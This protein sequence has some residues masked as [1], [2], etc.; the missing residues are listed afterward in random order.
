MSEM[1]SPVF[2]KTPSK[3]QKF[4]A[5]AK[6]W[7][8][9]IKTR[10]G[11]VLTRNLTITRKQFG[12]IVVLI[13]LFAAGTIPVVTSVWV[14]TPIID[15]DHVDLAVILSSSL[16]VVGAIF[17]GIFLDLMKNKR[18]CLLIAA[19][20]QQVGILLMTSMHMFVGTY[21]TGV[22]LTAFFTLVILMAAGGYLIHCTSILDRARV[23]AYSFLV[24]G[25]GV[26]FL[27]VFIQFLAYWYTWIVS[28]VL[29]V[30]LG[31]LLRTE[32]WRVVA[33]P[34]KSVSFWREMIDRGLFSYVLVQALYTFLCGVSFAQFLGS[35][36]FATFVF[37]SVVFAWFLVEGLLLDNFGRKLTL[38]LNVIL[39]AVV[40][41]FAGSS[42]DYSGDLLAGIFA[43]VLIS[44]LILAFVS[45]GDLGSE[46][47]NGRGLSLQM[48]AV[49]GGFLGGIIL[50][51]EVIQDL[52][53]GQLLIL[54]DVQSFA[55][56]L[57]MALMIPLKETLR[58]RDLVFREKLKALYVIYHTSGVL[59]HDH[60]FP[61]LPAIKTAKMTGSSKTPG[62]SINSPEEA[63]FNREAPPRGEGTE[64]SLAESETASGGLDPDLVSGGITGVTQ[65]FKEITQ[66][67]KQIRSLDQ[68]DVKV[69][70]E[71]GTHVVGVLFATD[72]FFLIRRKLR[73]FVEDFESQ[74]RA[75]L[76]DLHGDVEAFTATKRLVTKH[77]G[78]PQTG[79]RKTPARRTREVMR[80]P[81]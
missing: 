63:R 32:S 56:I 36:H 14:D 49:F 79:L 10:A 23:V 46:R 8:G 72:N 20:G 17:G 24:A 27:V 44:A 43:A 25:V 1:K 35:D 59:L 26:L 48:I 57:L 12:I 74:F 68:E 80:S 13:L 76:R 73:E 2:D 45:S 7:G 66:S 52:T 50:K 16:A 18:T 37:V 33:K 67:S 55:L 19:V 69:M 47:I 81:G 22:S 11:H 38:V 21:M 5:R 61:A 78:S 15:D 4:K 41:V 3:A 65:I 58:A 31:V 42:I 51:T 62:G 75:E 64:G 6:R 9:W 34:D 77:F 70:F 53:E 60:V 71:Y 28:A 30:G 40:L 39:L 54:N 29:F